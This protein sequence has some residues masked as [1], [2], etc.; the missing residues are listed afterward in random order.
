MSEAFGF[1][2]PDE[3]KV[4]TEK[5]YVNLVNRIRGNFLSYVSDLDVRLDAIISIFF[6]RDPDDYSLW[7]TTVFDEERNASFGAKIVWLGKIM[8]HDKDLKNEID[9]NVRKEIQQKL[10]EL[11][12]IRNDFAHNSAYNKDVK[13]EDIEKR[14][15]ILHEWDENGME[16]PKEFV[17]KDIM[18]LINDPWLVEHLDKIE[19]L[20][21]KIA[22][23]FYN[24]NSNLFK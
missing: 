18:N 16:V 10:D 20:T 7:R 9:E 21:E 22:E 3:S 24:R 1:D 17:M 4:L 6:L 8:K 14:L 15:I 11:R 19:K 13:S 2:L 23:K 5:E 12:K